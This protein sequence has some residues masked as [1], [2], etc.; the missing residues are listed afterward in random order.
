V[1]PTTSRRHCEAHYQDNR[2]SKQ[3]V[4]LRMPSSKLSKDTSFVEAMP[5]SALNSRRIFSYEFD[6][7]DFQRK[8]VQ[9]FSFQSSLFQTQ[10]STHK[11]VTGPF[12]VAHEISADFVEFY[13][14]RLNYLH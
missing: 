9:K 5:V 3:P 14:E 11:S 13:T 2:S 1:K 8:A 6:T 12:L 4:S 10:F 7:E